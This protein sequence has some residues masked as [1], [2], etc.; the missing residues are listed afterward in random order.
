MQK[1]D[2]QTVVRPFCFECPG[3]PA[4][5]FTRKMRV[6][7]LARYNQRANVESQSLTFAR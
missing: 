6:P 3:P 7:H 4:R 2:G 5:D 1:K